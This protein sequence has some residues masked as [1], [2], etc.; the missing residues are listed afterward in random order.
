MVSV[1]YAEYTVYWICFVFSMLNLYI[2]LYVEY[3][4]CWIFIS[5]LD[6]TPLMMIYIQGTRR[7]MITINM[8]INSAIMCRVLEDIKFHWRKYFLFCC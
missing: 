3:T 8:N 5:R 1:E 7:I 2:I 4:A 6:L